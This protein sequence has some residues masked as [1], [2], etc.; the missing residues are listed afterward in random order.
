MLRDRNAIDFKWNKVILSLDWPKRYGIFRSIEV[1]QKIKTLVKKS[2]RR[3]C[4][5]AMP[6]TDAQR[7]FLYMGRPL[8]ISQY[9]SFSYEFANH[10]KHI[11]Y[12]FPSLED[13][14][15]NSIASHNAHKTLL[16]RPLAG[17]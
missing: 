12:I 2:L 1:K 6:H 7:H 3:M 8:R 11:I 15:Q 4:T 17:R 14:A 16:C 13:C 5:A 10:A 9:S